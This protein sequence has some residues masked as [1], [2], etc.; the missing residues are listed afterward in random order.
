MSV[1]NSPLVTVI[2]VTYNSSAY[3][4]DAIESI[5][6]SSYPNFELI[7]GDDSSS[8]NTWEIVAG[9]RDPRIVKYRNEQNIGEYPNRNK[10]IQLAKGEY[11]IFI[12]GDDVIYPHGIAYFVSMMQAFPEAAMAIQKNYT[13]NILFP[14]LLDSS[15]VIKNYFFGKY[16][17]L[18]SS[19]ASNFF[20]T[21]VL[22]RFM[23]R[24]DIKSGDDEVRLR[25]G[26]QHAVLFV[27]GWVTWP[28]ET[29]GQAS[30]RIKPVGQLIARW[31][32]VM[33]LLDGIE[34]QAVVSEI[35]STLNRS[36]ARFILKALFLFRIDDNI[37]VI[38]ELQFD[39]IAVFKDLFFVSTVLDISRKYNT[40]K[41]YKNGFLRV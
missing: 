9:Y 30:A 33:P 25:I 1:A 2:T 11:L 15:E 40:V 8:D 41:P 10:A 22:K 38:N 7:I 5:L 23:L 18:S 21:D 36:L 20:K 13:N 3:V 39:F 12:D 14:A 37:A 35:R 27:Q 24:M 26:L 32:Y 6:A 16:N 29:P 28:R 31:N 17:L 19:F 34:D 4:R